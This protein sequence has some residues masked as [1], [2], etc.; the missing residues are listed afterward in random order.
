MAEDDLLKQVHEGRTQG[1]GLRGRP[2]V[3]IIRV[4]LE[5]W[6]EILAPGGFNVQRGS[7]GTGKSGDTPVKATC[8]REK[9]L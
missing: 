2:P 6:R 1:G 5:Y 9:F 8:L 4:T 7:A 3:R